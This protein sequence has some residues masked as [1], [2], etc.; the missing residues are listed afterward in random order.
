MLLLLT[1]VWLIVDIVVVVV[2]VDVVDAAVVVVAI[3]VAAAADLLLRPWAVCLLFFKLVSW[4]LACVCGWLTIKKTCVRMQVHAH[5]CSYDKMAI[6][7][8]A[9]HWHISEKDPAALYPSV[10]YDYSNNSK[11]ACVAAWLNN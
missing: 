11:T 10:Y 2:V 4:S 8:S 9:L 1:E 5:I 3:D 6:S 7:S